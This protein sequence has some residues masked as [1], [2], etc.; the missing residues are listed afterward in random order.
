MILY[1]SKHEFRKILI[2]SRITDFLVSV[3]D[4]EKKSPNSG[5][6]P[7]IN[8]SIT[9][10]SENI[11]EKVHLCQLANRVGLSLSRF[12]QRFKE[13]AG[14]PPGEFILRQKIKIATK[15]LIETDREI[16]RIAYDLDFSSSQYF[17]TVFRRFKDCSPTE[18]RRNMEDS[19][20]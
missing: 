4:F 3:I 6:S 13:E 2:R 8:D 10:I 18:Y 19:S 7:L 14:I 9:F 15:E 20:L 1:F 12:K 5:I 11:N 17:A 16:T